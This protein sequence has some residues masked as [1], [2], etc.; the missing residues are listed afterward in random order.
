M[1]EKAHNPTVRR[2]LSRQEIWL[3]VWT[4]TPIS[5]PAPEGPP[6]PQTGLTDDYGHLLVCKN[7]CDLE[8]E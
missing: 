8:R 6:F 3:R 4:S 1:I 7:E 5:A 2:L